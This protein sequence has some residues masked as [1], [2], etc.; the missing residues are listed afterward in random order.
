MVPLSYNTKGGSNQISCPRPPDF[1]RFG[2][3]FVHSVLIISIITNGHKIRG[4]FVVDFGADFRWRASEASVCV[5]ARVVGGY[6]GVTGAWWG[7][8]D[9]DNDIRIL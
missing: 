5:C 7:G 2:G 1:A 8:V 6:G 3:K 4:V 9:D